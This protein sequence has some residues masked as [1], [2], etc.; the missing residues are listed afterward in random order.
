[1]FDIQDKIKLIDFG[2]SKCNQINYIYYNILLRYF[3]CL[4]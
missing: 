4:L 1:M 3:Y 2:S